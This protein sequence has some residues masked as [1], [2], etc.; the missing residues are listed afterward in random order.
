MLTMTMYGCG[1]ASAHVRPAH[2]PCI[3]PHM[4]IM[5]A[6]VGVALPL[7]MCGLLMLA[8]SWRPRSLALTLGQCFCLAFTGTAF[9][10]A[11]YVVDVWRTFYGEQHSCREVVVR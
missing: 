5:A 7:L 10:I 3:K 11:S 8:S 1:P 4:L 2:V 9:L 6:H